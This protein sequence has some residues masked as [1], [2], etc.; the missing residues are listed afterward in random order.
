MSAGQPDWVK[1]H[2][3][4]KLPKEAR[5]KIPVLAQLDSAEKV[6]EG[7]R[8]GVCNDCR[9]KF[10]PD[11]ETSKKAEVVTVKCEVLNCEFIAQGKLPMHAANS[12]RGHM[13]KEHAPK[14]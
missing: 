7:L 2:S 11:E 1:L 4:G 3:M 10:F 13:A 12:L 5:G 9:E 14:K 6:I 8:K